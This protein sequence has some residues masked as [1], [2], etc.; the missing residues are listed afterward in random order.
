MGPSLIGLFAP[1]IHKLSV[2]ILS[3]DCTQLPLLTSPLLP[4]PLEMLL[5]VASAVG[6]YPAVADVNAGVGVP[7]V[8]AVVALVIVSAVAGFPA[9]LLFF[10]QSLF[11]SPGC[12]WCHC[13]C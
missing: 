2:S 12:S 11:W 8:L 7:K 10:L 4:A 13:C 3:S 1:I 9:V 6:V 5:P